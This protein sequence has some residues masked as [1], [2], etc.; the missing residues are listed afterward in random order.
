MFPY[1]LIRPLSAVSHCSRRGHSVGSLA[2]DVAVHGDG[3]V[4]LDSVPDD[5][6]AVKGDAAAGL[7]RAD[8]LQGAEEVDLVVALDASRPLER[9]VGRVSG[10]GVVV[11]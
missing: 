6:V 2:V 3:P 1:A 4:G 11:P 5:E 8:D 10:A 9:P 7:D